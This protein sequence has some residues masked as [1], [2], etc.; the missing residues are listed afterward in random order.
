MLGV[1]VVGGG[2]V[3]GAGADRGGEG[4]VDSA[5]G[6]EVEAAAQV[7]HAVGAVVQGGF[8]FGALEGV[9]GVGGFAALRGLFG[10]AVGPQPMTAAAEL[11]VL[12]AG[13]PCGILRRAEHG[14][15]T[16]IV[17]QQSTERGTAR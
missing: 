2:F 11:T 14:R 5:A 12:L 4:L 9:L 10:A 17:P 13:T 15:L 1:G 8:A 6:E 16:F 3:L 7:P